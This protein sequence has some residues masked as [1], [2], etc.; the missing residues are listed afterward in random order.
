MSA[1][2]RMAGWALA[3]PILLALGPAFAQQTTTWNYQYDANG[4][5]RQVTDP[6]SNVTTRQYDALN[7]LV[8]TI[9]PVPQTGSAAPQIGLGYDG[10]SQL[11]SVT[12]PRS[13]MTSYTVDGLGNIGTTSSPDTGTASSVFDPAGDLIS[14][15]DAKNKRATYTYDAL[16]RLTSISYPTGTGTTF[17]YD[18][19]TNAIGKLT[20]IT[21]ESGNTTYTY[22]NF[23]RLASKTQTAVIASSQWPRTV[24]YTYGTAGSANGK[25]T[26]ITYPSGNR[27]N[28]AFDAA[29]RMS[30][31]TLNP[32][33]SNGV[34]TNTGL[35]IAVVSN[36]TYTPFGAPLSWVWGPSTS[37]DAV[38]RTYDLDGRLTSYP[39]GNGS[40][41]GLVRTVAYDSS[42]RITGF[43]HVDGSG[44]SQ[45]TWNHTFNY[46]NLDRLTGWGQNT[47]AYG[48]GYDA[49]GNRTGYSP[50]ANNYTNTI[51]STSNQ[52]SSTTGP[53][54]A[55]SNTYDADGHLTADG[56]F[57]YTYSDR[58]RLASVSAGSNTV[59][60]LYNGLE[61]RVI[62][63]GPAAFVS[64]GTQVYVYDE[65]SHLLGEY[66]NSLATVQETV[67]LGDTPIIVLTQT[68]SGSPSTT[69]TNVYNVYTDQIGAARMIT[70]ASSD[71]M[72]WRWDSTDPFGVLPPNTNPAG[73]GTFI[74]NPGLPGQLYD[75]ETG[76]FYN[77]NRNY[78]PVL[79]RYVQS[80][81]I[82]LKGG[83]NTYAY[84]GGSPLTHA[85][86]PGLAADACGCYQ[87]Y[88]QVRCFSVPGYTV[89]FC[90]RHTADSCGNVRILNA[91]MYYW[92]DRSFNFI[93]VFSCDKFDQMLQPGVPTQPPDII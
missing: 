82:G 12:D 4:N 37:T 55:R 91:G 79:G 9:Q 72:V 33:N 86:P 34:G 16:N 78:D 60:Y 74:Y 59:S 23:G 17:T 39:L 29:G 62:K 70:Q 7:R 54:P 42:S 52:L 67:F 24:S 49:S 61:Q 81:P 32:T 30:A 71:K 75:A 90:T 1:R 15:T 58:G 18:Q 21:D 63:T 92:P 35:T 6:L 2:D 80:D 83:I 46:D 31:I 5:L 48:Y 89:V 40:Q 10:L 14:R 20:K 38:T 84:V 8:K 68:V 93:G 76:Q 47:T 53:S 41:S 28:Y 19:G 64:T 57:T 13:L 26:S 88:C 65:A 73:L 87:I 25:L 51:A 11:T 43:T 27:I 45:P 69:T 85:D 56:T 44:V 36:I 50:G 66:N 22:D 3:T 77:V